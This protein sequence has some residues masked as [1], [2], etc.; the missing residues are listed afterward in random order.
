MLGMP[1]IYVMYVYS[2]L[3]PNEI[4]YT[5]NI[6]DTN[7]IDSDFVI[8]P[9]SIIAHESELKALDHLNTINKKVFVTGIFANVF[10]EKYKTKNSIVI[11]DE[12]ENFFYKIKKNNNLN[13]EYLNGLFTGK[14]EI[15]NNNFQDNLDDLPF[16]D[17]G[18]YI[19]KFPLRNNFL[20]FNNK[21]AIPILATRGCPYSCFKYCTYPLQQGRKVRARSV[22]NIVDEIKHWKNTLKTNKFVF[23]DPVFSINRKHTVELCKALIKEN[24]NINYLVETHLN[25]LDDEL[26][27]L[28]KKSGLKMVYVGIESSHANVLKDID[29]FTVKNDK[30]IKRR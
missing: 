9:S 11:P 16:P 29:R 30:Q 23:R 7:L 1:A 5:R 24:I 12:A 2:I 18:T 20:N 6:N 14:Y 4:I 28:L 3:K 13:Y 10:K 26:L 15:S 8:L 21:V 27:D 25:N 17:W 19:K 22:Q